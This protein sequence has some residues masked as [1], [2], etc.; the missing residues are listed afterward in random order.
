MKYIFRSEVDL[1]F[2]VVIGLNLFVTLVILLIFKS[3]FGVAIIGLVVLIIVLLTRSTKYTIDVEQQTLTISSL[4][5]QA[6][7]DINKITSINKS[8]SFLASASASLNRIDIRY[9][10]SSHIISPQK[11]KHFISILQD[12]NP[13]IIVNI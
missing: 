4:F 3:Y 11:R 12:I 1:T 6:R 9:L 7:L 8:S 10:K 13:D 5:N 2:F